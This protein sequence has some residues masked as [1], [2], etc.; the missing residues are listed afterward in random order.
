MAGLGSRP[1]NGLAMYAL[2]F[3]ACDV[4]CPWSNGPAPLLLPSMPAQYAS[5]VCQPSM[6]AQY[7]RHACHAA[8]H[9]SLAH[10]PNADLSFRY[11][12]TID[13]ALALAAALAATAFA[14]ADRRFRRAAGPRMLCTL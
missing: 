12:G 8:M 2:D 10:G 14:F 7:A 1:V 13:A 3:D 11:P 9:A 6:P 4:R 5:P